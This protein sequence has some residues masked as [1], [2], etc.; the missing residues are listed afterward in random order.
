MSRHTL[1]VLAAFLLAATPATALGAV[2]DFEVLRHDDP[3]L[4]HLR[5]VV[6]DTSFVVQG[7]SF[8]DQGTSFVVQGTSFVTIGT[9]LNGSPPFVGAKASFSGSTALH[10]STPDSIIVFE[11]ESGAAFDAISIDLAEAERDQFP[12]ATIEFEGQ[13]L[14]G[15]SVTQQFTLDG[16]AYSAETFLFDSSFANIVSLRWRQNGFVLSN[17]PECTNCLATHQFD[18][19]VVN[20]VPE[21]STALLHAFALGVLAALVVRRRRAL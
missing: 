19:I 18:N 15:G 16:I 13:L 17:N 5:F 4:L 6:Q 20:L 8:V 21:P 14:S 1:G 9:L 11:A 2:M 12:G 10:S 7:T 3:N